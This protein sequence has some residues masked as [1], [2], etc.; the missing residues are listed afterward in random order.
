MVAANPAPSVA[1]KPAPSVAAKPAPLK[2]LREWTGRPPILEGLHISRDPNRVR[3]LQSPS[4]GILPA[5]WV[6]E[7]LMSFIN[8]EEQKSIEDW[9]KGLRESVDDEGRSRKRFRYA[10]E[11]LSATNVLPLIVGSEGYRTHR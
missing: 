3:E 7:Q 2:K 11:L 8:E 4:T 10:R 5:A 6:E 1:A 9:W